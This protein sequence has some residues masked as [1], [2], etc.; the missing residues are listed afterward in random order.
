M[1]VA[2]TGA[3]AIG[4]ESVPN[5][6][7]FFALPGVQGKWHPATGRTTKI[8]SLGASN[9][10]D[11]IEEQEGTTNGQTQRELQRDESWEK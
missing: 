3:H 7:A 6:A 5:K 11:G 1:L 2:A 4:A 10:E 8:V 9:V